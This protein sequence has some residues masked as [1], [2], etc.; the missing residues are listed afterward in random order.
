MKKG[1]LLIMALTLVMSVGFHSSADARPRR[2]IKSPR[3]GFTETPKKKDNANQTNNG[4]RPGTAAGAGRTGFWGGGN[5][6]RGLMVGG[7]AGL[8]FGSLFSG[9]GAFGNLLG[10]LINVIA[11]IAVVMLIRAIFS[12]FRNNRRRPD[13]R[14]RY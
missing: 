1:I 5:F 10:L 11:I 3:Q 13:D 9:W 6:F 8:L 4:A 14:S 12:Y 7:L 2:A